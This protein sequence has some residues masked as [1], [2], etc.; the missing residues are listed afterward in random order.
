[1]SPAAAGETGIFNFDMGNAD[2]SD[3][4][5]VYFDDFVVADNT[6]DYPLSDLRVLPIVPTATGTHNLDASPSSFFFQHD[7][8]TG[9]ALTNAETTSYSRVDDAPINASTDRIY[10]TGAPGSGQYVEL[11]LGDISS[12]LGTPRAV[13]VIEAV[14]QA[15]AGG[16]V[17]TSKI[18]D[19]NGTSNTN[20]QAALDVNSATEVYKT[21]V[22]TTKP[23]SG[24]W[25]NSAINSLKYRFGFTTDANP[26][27]RLY[28]V[29]LEVVVDNTIQYLRPASTITTNTWRTNTAGTDLHTAIDES[30]PIDSDYIVSVTSP[31]SADISE[32]KLTSGTDPLSSTGHII[33]YR[34]KKDL[35]GGDQI[36]LVVRLV[37]GT[38]VLKTWTHTNIGA[39]EVTAEQTLSAGEADS[40]TD[41]TDLR[42]RFEATKP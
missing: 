25:T 11:Q 36:D 7:G 10:A 32:V 29:L 8:T 38:T 17:Y 31:A 21:K 12:N 20:V 35:A 18:T 14:Q 3:T 22:I 1:L 34:Y 30:A 6:A 23:S 19:D 16:S 37:Q 5:D 15:S 41:Y 24:A 39:T 9:A 33:S 2:S 26:E 13:K 27:I 42:L 4:C 40:I 28:G